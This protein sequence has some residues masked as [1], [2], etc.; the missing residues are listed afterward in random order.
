MGLEEFTDEVQEASTET[1]ETQSGNEVRDRQFKD[2]SPGKSPQAFTDLP[3]VNPRAIKYQIN[4]I[5]TDW[6]HQF[7]T[8]RFDSGELVMYGYGKQADESGKTVAVF[9]TIQ[10]AIDDITIEE[11]Q[12]IHVVCWDLE[13]KEMLNDGEYI[14]PDGE[15]NQNL[16]N[17]VEEQIEELDKYT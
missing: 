1:E 12:D 7:S 8:R 14:K 10:S 16:L 6:K 9:T 17:A 11:H 4:T 5:N 3:M 2:N 13:E 15:W